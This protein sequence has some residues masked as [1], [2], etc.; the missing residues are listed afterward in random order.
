MSHA[1]N[2]PRRITPL[3]EHPLFALIAP[4]I[5]IEDYMPDGGPVNPRHRLEMNAPADPAFRRCV[6]ELVVLCDVC[7]DVIHPI[8]SSPFRGRRGRL[9]ITVTCPI[10]VKIACSRMR[11]TTAYDQIVAAVRALRQDQASGLRARADQLPL[12]TR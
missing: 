6:L 10:N 2:R 5:R 7:D 9:Y 3:L 1:K 12:W 8:R 4:W 11:P